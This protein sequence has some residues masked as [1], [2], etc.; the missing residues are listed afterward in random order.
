M[1][2]LKKKK[3]EKYTLCQNGGQPHETKEQCYPDWDCWNSPNPP[4]ILFLDHVI[5]RHFGGNQ[6]YL[7]FEW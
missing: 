4:L 3:K 6:A 7:G 2:N 1:I 5:F